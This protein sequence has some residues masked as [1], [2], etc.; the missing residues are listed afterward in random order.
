[1]LPQDVL[2]DSRGQ[3]GAEPP[4]QFDTG[5]GAVPEAVDMSIRLMTPEE[6]SLVTA[7][8]PYAYQGRDDRPAVGASLLCLHCPGFFQLCA[9]L[10]ASHPQA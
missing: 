4:L 8:A 6:T 1:M 5:M 10:A 3:A 9:S 7:A 2:Y